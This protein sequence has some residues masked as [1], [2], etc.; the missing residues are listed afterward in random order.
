MN[1]LPEKWCIKTERNDIGRLIGKWFNDQSSNG[2]YVNSCLGEYYHS[3]NYDNQSILNKGVL[4]ASFANYEPRPGYTEITFEQFKQYAMNEFPEN[5]YIR[6]TAENQDTVSKWRLS[7]ATS[8]L[9][10]EKMEIGNFIIS[11]HEDGSYY[12][13]GSSERDLLSDYPNYKEIDLPTFLQITR[14][15]KTE[16]KK[17]THTVTR[18]QFKQGYELACSEWK[19]KLMKSVGQNLV[20]SDETTVSQELIEEMHRA[21]ANQRQKDFLNMLFPD[22]SLINSNNLKVGEAMRIGKSEGEHTGKIILR[23]YDSLVDINQP[24]STWSGNPGFIGTKVELE[25]KVIG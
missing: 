5:W 14:M 11:Y 2:C 19:E 23:T 25:I 18:E 1:K 6:V 21:A 13:G 10:K 4:S 12:Y 7:K 9:G 24:R 20:L 17:A 16:M 15:Q 22:P 8:F 3:H